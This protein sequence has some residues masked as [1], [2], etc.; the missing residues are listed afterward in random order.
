MTFES[1]TLSRREAMALLG[2]AVITITACGG[3]SPSS[4]SSGGSTGDKTG[5]ISGNH[6]HSASIDSARLQAGNALDL[7]IRG[8]AT[9]PHTVSLGASEVVQIRNGDRVSKTTSNDDGHTHQVT[10]N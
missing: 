3:D 8:S 1:R 4:P 2:G 5:T 10:F 7:D 9:H 6:G